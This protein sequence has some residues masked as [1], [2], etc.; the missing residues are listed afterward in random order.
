M[1]WFSFGM[2]V[3]AVPVAIVVMLVQA[4]RDLARLRERLDLL[5]RRLDHDGSPLTA[6]PPAGVPSPEPPEPIPFTRMQAP[7]PP[8][9]E[10]APPPG[11]PAPPLP[12]YRA[13]LE[14]IDG[15]RLEEMVGGVWLQNVGSVL[16]LLGVFFLILWAYTTG[17]L[18]PGW[19]VVA[20]VGLGLVM[21]WRGDRTAR[22]VPAFGHA[23]IGVG[24]GIVY[25]SLY[26]GHF[27]L[28]VLS[29]GI[30]LALLLLV[31]L[32]ALSLGLHYRVPTV[33]ALG[34]LGAFL[35]Q[36]LAEWMSLR[37]FSLPPWGRVVYVAAVDAVV[38]AL[39][40]RAGWGGLSLLALLLTT[41]AWG[42]DF[43]R[44]TQGWGLHI[45]QALVMTGF[46][47][48]LVPRLAALRDRVRPIE[49]AVVALAPLAT[50]A[51]LAPFL[52]RVD[53]VPAA[54]LVLSLAA[55]YLAAAMWV[56]S[57]R[58]DEDLWR[59]LTGAATLFLTVGLALWMG[60]S[61][62]P[63]AWCIEGALLVWLGLRARGGWLRGCG[64]VVLALG[65]A[66]L[67]LDLDSGWNP[68]MVPFFYPAGVRNLV[69]LA[70]LVTS[71]ILLARARPRFSP[72]EAMLSRF[73]SVGVN[74]L[75]LFWSATEAGHWASV[76]EAGGG[77]WAQPPDLGARPEWQRLRTLSAVFTS[78]AWTLQAGALLAIG[79][80]IGS[81]FARWMGLSLL[82]L[83]VLK[84]LS[85]DLQ[86]VDVFWR[87]LTAIVVGVV[88]L[89]VSYA[90]QRRN[91]APAQV[92]DAGR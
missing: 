24:I 28:H 70:A 56:E 31:S 50:I 79:W 55:L 49:I 72:E 43:A 78:A 22:T 85:F 65:A 11:L 15:R 4:R 36:I 46:G 69:G 87:F 12:P 20:G 68:G 60:E 51:T 75:I 41:F 61:W 91:R 71:A 53:R 39:A 42:S 92:G 86:M 66:V 27:T 82:A 83:T 17:R 6:V 21:V 81:A 3:L 76:L 74:A 63:V 23:L 84:F 2:L 33:A 26:L 10:P 1:F 45:A 54:A 18:G 34:V 62:T 89:A 35:P 29:P 13:P 7:V 8:P 58:E 44:S 47:L 30:A 19:L 64:Y 73:W 16:V 38:L 32:G 14:R 80:R 25:L 57:R 5:E 52:A 37:G 40:T 9:A 48:V 90:Y 67:A 77:R 88:L 59:P